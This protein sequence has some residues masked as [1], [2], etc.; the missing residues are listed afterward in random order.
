MKIDALVVEEKDGPFEREQIELEDPAPGEALVR[1]VASG[2]CHTD[3]ITRSGDLPMPF[4]AVLGHEG[5]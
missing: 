5:A 3:A 4:P 2:V 1:I